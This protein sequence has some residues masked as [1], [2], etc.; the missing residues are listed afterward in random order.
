VPSPTAGRP[1]LDMNLVLLSVGLA[2][3]TAVPVIPEKLRLGTLVCVCLLPFLLR[4]AAR[5]S[6]VRLLTTT[7]ILWAAGQL[8]SDQANGLGLSISMPIVLAVTI[9]VTTTTLA[10]FANGDFRNIRYLTLGVASGLVLELVIFERVS[11][12]DPASWKFG[13]NVPV[14]LVLLA[15][16]DLAWRRGNRIPSFLGLGA[17]CGL[18]FWSDHR[19]LTGVAALTAVF[20]LLPRRHHQRHPRILLTAGGIALLLGALSILFVDSAQAGLFGKRS[21]SQVREYG[22]NPVSILVNVRPELYQEFSLFLQRPLTGFGSQ[23]QLSASVYQESLEFVQSVGVTDI[24]AVSDYWMRL[25]IPGVSA[26]SMAADSW[27]RAGLAAIPFWILVVVLALW[28]GTT[29][30]H[31]RSSPL[32]IMWTML[33]LWDTFFSPL[34]SSGASSLAAYLA[35]AVVTISNAGETSRASEES[36]PDT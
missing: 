5:D 16:T 3:L 15:F 23:P 12:G 20:V 13:L 28:A 34:T 18:G 8:V 7:L 35:L 10:Y 30:L 1:R 33:V 17:I 29:A 24:E 6:R 22:S 21:V 4:D 26:H 14:S 19:G 36:N 27:A 25:T 9:L 11:L 31:F 32:L 2:L